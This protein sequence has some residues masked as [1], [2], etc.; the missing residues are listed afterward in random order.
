GVSNPDPMGNPVW[1]WLVRTKQSA[2]A[3][4]ELLKG[5][6]STQAGPSWCF[7]RFGQSET[8]LPD[9]RRIFVAGEH[10]DHYDPDFYI[11]NDV[12]VEHPGGAIS[13]YG[14][15]LDCFPPTDFHTATLVDSKIIVIGNL[16]YPESRKKKTSDVYILDVE[17]LV[18]RH[19]QTSGEQPGWIHEHKA[20][21]S[22]HGTKVLITGGKLD[23]G[24]GRY[25]IENIDDWQLDLRTWNWK[26]VKRRNWQRWEIARA[27]KSGNRIW[28]I[29]Q[30]LW[31]SNVGWES[32]YEASIVKLR[33]DLGAEPDVKSVEALY[34]PEVSH[35]PLPEIEEEYGS[36]RIKVDGVTVRYV[37]ETFTIQVTVEGDLPELTIRHLVEDVR[38]KLAKLENTECYAEIIA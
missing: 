14:Y 17:S 37:E 12:V 20:S 15:P 22:E 30:A 19:V 5:P 2:Y 29:R 31:N 21:L 9:G 34:S 1:D 26:C 35:D 24:E 38:K 36:Y 27:D 25:L 7:D 3:A 13:I 28:E 32:D 8:M 11:Y 33:D 16:G 23:L 10:E 4:N 18:F 6:S